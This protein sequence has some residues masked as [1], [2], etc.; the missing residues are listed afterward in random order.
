MT[1]LEN[2]VLRNRIISVA[3]GVPLRQGFDFLAPETGPEPQPGARVKVPFGP[4]KL[5]GV[6]L[7]VKSTSDFPL[8][9]LKRAL[10]ILD[11]K[12]VFEANLLTTLRWVSSY[13]LAP[14]G[15][16]META[17]PVA[18]RRGLVTTP[19]SRKTWALSDHGRSSALDELNRAPLQ[20]AIIRRFMQSSSLCS[21]D[22]KQES[23]GWRQAV[24]AL[25]EKGW[26]TEYEDEPKLPSRVVSHSSLTLTAAQQLAA[27]KLQNLISAETFSCSLLHGVTGSG[28][29][30]VYF[31][32]MDEVL[33]RGQQVL[34]MVPEIGLTPQLVMRIE[35]RFRHSVALMHSALNESERH[36]SWWH[37]KQGSA[38]IIIGTRSS[39]FSSF[40]N[41]G[42]IIVDEEHD[43]SFKQQDGVR[44]HAR[45]VAIYRAKQHSIPIVLGSATPSLE[46]YANAESGRYHRLSLKQRATD[47][48]LPTIELVDL[49]RQPSNDG[50]SP[51]MLEEI[52]DTLD[53][54]KQV[55]LFLN[56]RGYAPVLYCKACK[57]ACR[58]HRCD[59]HL[60]L[61]RRA[62]KMRCHHCGYEGPVQQKC[63]ACNA[64]EMV[65]V[66]SGTQRVEDAL[67][68]RF[69]QARLLRIDRDSTRRKGELA[70]LLEQARTGEADILLGTQLITKG[71]D[72][73]DVAMVGVLDADQGLYSTDFRATENLFQQLL[74]VAG[75]AG[76]RSETGKVLI[77]TLFPEH[78][79]FENVISHDFVGFAQALLDERKVAQFPPFG[80]FAL[81]RA[82]STH[83]AKALQFLR[84]A[85][86]DIL[87]QEA[88]QVLDVVPAPM[89]RRAGKYR[90]QLLLSATQRSALNASLQQWLHF[91]AVD[92]EA[93]RLASSVRWS[94]DIDPLDHY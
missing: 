28:K 24:N 14:I 3:V 15:E 76:R 45:D 8:N 61:H 79:F 85:R 32:A 60:T 40:A 54:N 21:S 10:E 63:G 5:Q 13:Y 72:F 71:H 84:K 16:V 93:K 19:A 34:L 87:P 29:T 56:R 91:I 20:L 59:S 77:Q 26:L 39:I 27:G 73:P 62:N 55:M 47:V 81:L 75:R 36:L 52:R 57:E 6:I 64:S 50:L 65:E 49:N 51:R 42:L 7:Q 74:Q 4:R 90:A 43:G 30:E 80:Y 9:K 68:L 41:L 25:L 18:L 88:V 1:S 78:A 67:S 31:T 89:E 86:Q 58:C 23:S 66:G 48:T 44:Y 37:A 12:S 17:M 11:H 2:S 35:Q 70:G 53:N 33:A 83:Q 82:E 94:L 69:P 92:V 46:T 38:K 22:F